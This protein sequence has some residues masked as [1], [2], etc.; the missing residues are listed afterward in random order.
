MW[1]RI[2]FQLQKYNL[3]YEI[4]LKIRLLEENIKEHKCECCGLTKWNGLDIPLELH[5][6]DGNRHNHNLE[7]IQLLCPNCHAQTETY[8]SKNINHNLG[9]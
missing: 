1:V 9:V 8:R 2:P 4:K 3:Y 6:K 5:H 7:N